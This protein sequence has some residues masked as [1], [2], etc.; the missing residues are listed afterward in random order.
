MVALLAIAAFATTMSLAKAKRTATEKSYTI[1]FKE[2][3]GHTDGDN[4]SQVST[5]GDLIAEGADYVESFTKSNVYQAREG[6]GIKLGTGSKTG[7][8]TLTLKNAVKPTKIVVSV[9][10]YSDSEKTFK[11]FD[12]EYNDLTTT[13]A[14]KTAVFD[15]DT[16]VSTITFGTLTKRCYVKSVTVFYNED[17]EA[18]TTAFTAVW[19]FQNAEPATLAEMHIEGTT[20]TVASTLKPIE[21]AVDAT[22]GKLQRREQGDAQ[23]NANTIL[24]VPVKKAGDEVTVVSY[25]GYHNYTVAGNAADADEVK[26]TAVDADV[27][28]GYVEIVATA[29]SY[30]YKIQ[31]VVNVPTLEVKTPEIKGDAKFVEKQDITITCETEGA[32]IYYTTDGTEPTA[33]STE[34][35]APFEIEATTTVK[36]IAIKADAEGF[37]FASEVASADFTIYDGKATIAELNALEDKAEFAYTGEALVVAQG[38]AGKYAYTYIKDETASALIFDDGGTKTPENAVGKKIAKN[39]FGSVKIYHALKELVPADALTLAEGEAVDVDYPVVEFSYITADHANEAVMLSGVSYSFTN[40]EELTITKGEEQIAAINKFGLVQGFAKKG[41]EY[42]IT[43]VVN[44]DNDKVVFW[45]IKFEEKPTVDITVTPDAGTDISEAIAQASLGHFV[46]NITI[47]LNAVDASPYTISKPIEAYASVIINGNGATIDASAL[48]GAFINYTTVTGEKASESAYTKVDQI[49][50]DQVIIESLGNS[51]INSAAGKVL[52]TKVELTNSVVEIV[53]NN[54]VF[55]L[56]GGYAENMLVENST[57]WSAEGHKGFFFKADGKP[58][59]VTSTSTTTW[60]VNKST[61]YQIAVG[62]KANNSNGGIKGKKTTTMVLTNSI[63]YNF[64]SNVGNEVNGWLWGQNN[65]YNEDGSLKG[66]CNVTY[67]NN[68]YWSAEGEVAGWT[69]AEKGGS[70]QTG[71]ALKTNP[72][73]QGLWKELAEGEKFFAVDELSAQALN[74]TGDTRWGAWAPKHYTIAVSETALQY[75]DITVQPFAIEDEV[76]KVEVKEKNGFKLAENGLI[77]KV[78]AKTTLKLTDNS[79]IMPPSNVA[80]DAKFDVIA[81]DYELAPAAGTDIAA[82]LEGLI[83]RNLKLTLAENGAYIITKPITLGGNLEII[84]NGATIDAAGIVTGEGEAAT[85]APFII[86][87]G[88]EKYVLLGKDEEEKDVYDASHFDIATATIKDVTVKGLK[89]AFI[90]DAQK[91]LL[92]VL[93]IDNSIIEMP[94]AGKN[95]IDFNS[96]GYVGKV[97]VNNSTIYAPTKNTGFFAQYGS[98]PKNFPAAYV[99][100]FKQEFDV[101]NSTIVNIANGK[102]FCDLKQNGTDQN[103]YTIKNNIFADCGKDGQVVVGF[104]KGQASATPAWDVDGNLFMA[105]GANNNAAEIAKAGKHIVGEGEAAEEKDIVQ[106]CVEA[107]VTFTDAAA[108]NFSKTFLKDPRIAE[109]PAVGDPRWMVV[110]TTTAYGIYIDEAI[111][112]GTVTPSKT[113]SAADETIKLTVTPAEGYELETLVVKIGKTEIEV[114]EDNSFLMPAA[115]VTVTATF[116]E[117]ATGINNVKTNTLDNAVIYNLQG[118]RVDKSQAKGGIFI[119]NGKKVVIK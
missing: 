72:Y 94:D 108:G 110:K 101:Q 102:N 7:S 98:R 40:E 47:N 106:N 59:D 19:D 32:K 95:V 74:A 82:A 13:F 78:G 66:G 31:A 113:W 105:K 25:P 70:D 53:G 28:A 73:F 89:D 29:T 90:K 22:N 45:P 10:G 69:D 88:S 61:L 16:E 49:K 107:V 117:V 64:A 96:K 33:A 97:V 77:V 92:G 34:Y 18:A 71:T 116:K 91:T 3:A 75:A 68:T 39:W 8:L 65:S 38:V 109:L 48:E 26:Y 83:V 23:F 104:N 42:N 20:G 41:V 76:V 12:T 118:V 85:A 62:K 1:T 43:G 17:P 67:A 119:V 37:E 93:T 80:I 2:W 15:G 14:D 79:F 27:T 55:G 87:N 11:L 44:V 24:R 54:N 84:G 56:G 46:K 6:R 30:L 99:A 86:L 51:I 112:N 9:R 103:V 36:A 111:E 52:F 21:M 60:T 81:A 114:A 4:T 58:G 57:I 115:D 100:N 50:I 35:A 63:L 5:L